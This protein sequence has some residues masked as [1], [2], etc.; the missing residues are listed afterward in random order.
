MKDIELA[1]LFGLPTSTVADWKSK[2]NLN[3]NMKFL[4]YKFISSLPDEMIKERIEAIKLIEDIEV[5]GN[6]EFIKKIFDNKD[7]FEI[8]NGYSLLNIQDLTNPKQ[9][10][11]LTINKISIFKNKNDK[12]IV[13][14]FYLPF[15]SNTLNRIYHLEKEYKLL[16]E[17]YNIDK[18]YLVLG[19]TET[20]KIDDPNFCK[21][22]NNLEV[23]NAK[24]FTDELYNRKNI[25]FWNDIQIRKI[26]SDIKV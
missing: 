15:N 5:V 17:T 7:K 1:K 21:S 9:S 16:N 14:H 18:I 3:G 11:F 26:I 10:K 6:Q 25:V 8:F 2:K 19:I 22:I 24:Y 13:M 23:L 12:Y 4:L 20:V